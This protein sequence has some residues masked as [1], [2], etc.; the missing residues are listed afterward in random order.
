MTSICSLGWT[1]LMCPWAGHT[2]YSCMAHA[3][4]HVGHVSCAA[5][6]AQCKQEAAEHHWVT[7]GAEDLTCPLSTVEFVARSLPSTRPYCHFQSSSCTTHCK[8]IPILCLQLSW[9]ASALRCRPKAAATRQRP[10]GQCV[11]CSTHCSVL[12]FASYSMTTL[13]VP[14]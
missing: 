3:V 8:I 2:G 13:N 9:L 10:P 4:D 5:F 1:L 11:T 7:S 14:A 6:Q 12:Q